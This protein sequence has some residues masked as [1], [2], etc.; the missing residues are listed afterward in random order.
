MIRTLVIAGMMIAAGPA[1]AEMAAPAQKPAKPPKETTVRGCTSS[2]FA[3]C[4]MLVIGKENVMLTAKAGVAVPPAK[5][6]VIAKG[7]M[8]AAPPN[9]CNV[10]R[11]FTASN[12]IAT[13]RACK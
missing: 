5:T 12:I 7:I 2:G 11:Q 10:K 6:Y 4:S 13:K 3:G 9:V 1:L 8:G